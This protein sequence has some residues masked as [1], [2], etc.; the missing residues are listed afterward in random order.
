MALGEKKIFITG[1][2]GFIGRWLLRELV[3]QGHYVLALKRPTSSMAHLE[4]VAD[5][6]EWLTQQNG[7]KDTVLN[8]HP[9]TVYNLAWQGVAADGRNSYEKQVENLHLQQTILDIARLSG[10]K[11]IVGMGSQAEYGRFDCKIDESHEAHPSTAYGA[12]KL[13]AKDVMEAFCSQYGMDWYWFRLF[14][15]FGPGEDEHWLI[16][17]LIHNILQQPSMDLTPGEQQM[18]YLYVGEVARALA[19]TATRDAP[20]GVYNICSDNPI[21]LR[22][23]VEGIRN[24]INPNFSLHFG[25]LPYRKGQSMFMQGDTQLLS[26]NIYKL[27]TTDFD[28]RLQETI[29]FYTK[30]YGK[31]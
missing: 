29:D 26:N 2:T 24:R 11:K 3:A 13:A 21:T 18:C 7:W 28:Q 12:C 4:G 15:C 20:S 30:K 14:T 17:S 1:A 8:F 25:A 5:K 6:V 31:Q 27:Q 9:E 16:P 10:A 22:K 19:A 23:L